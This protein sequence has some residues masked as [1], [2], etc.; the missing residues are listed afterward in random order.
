M[1]MWSAPFSDTNPT[2]EFCN[3]AISVSWPAKRLPSACSSSTVA[4]HAS[5]CASLQS[6]PVNSRIDAAKI[7]ASSGVSA[8]RYGLSAGLGN[9]C[10]ITGS[11]AHSSR[12]LP[13]GAVLG[14]LDD[15]AHRGEFVADAIGF[16]EVFSRT[17]GGAI[18]D[19]A[20]HPLGVDAARLLL[21]LLPRRGR[22]R[23]E[24][25]E[26]QGS[27]EFIAIPL[28]FRS[29]IPKTMERG[30]H[31][32]RVEIVG[33]RLDHDGRRLATFR[34]SRNSIPVVERP[35]A[36]FHALH[37]PVDRRAVMR[38]EH[39]EPQ[40]F[41]W[42]IRKQF[43]DGDKVAEA[44]RHLVAFDLQKTVVHPDIGHAAFVERAAALRELVLMMR[45]HEINA[46]AMD[47]ELFA[48]M[49]PSHRRALDMPPRT[50]GS[51]N[52]RRRWP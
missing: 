36:L 7:A 28:V 12:D 14:I 35:G 5:C 42:P 26:P 19:Q 38:L 4:A 29:G 24:S 21:A 39:V 48:E 1:S 41:A 6:A 33:Q 46:P 15:D 11:A 17:R 31:L 18:G 37:G 2:G 13:G 9:V 44:L 51:H 23:E 8:A 27:G 40:H 16:L 50:P 32:R 34:I 3:V 22:L 25:K 10:P 30:N 47:V 20:I 49:L 52:A 43:P 45:K